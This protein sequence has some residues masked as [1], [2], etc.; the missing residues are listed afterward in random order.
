MEL[1]GIDLRT[2]PKCKKGSLIRRPL[3]KGDI[4]L[5]YG[6]APMAA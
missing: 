4:M 3:L 2:C 1:T 5:C 6:S